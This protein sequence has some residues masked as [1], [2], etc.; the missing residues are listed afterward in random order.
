[1]VDLKSNEY[2]FVM[3]YV[4]FQHIPVYSIRK[5]LLQEILRVLKPGGLF[6][7][8]MLFAS[9]LTPISYYDDAP[10]DK[11]ER[12]DFQISSVDQLG[13]DLDNIGFIPYMYKVVPR[14]EHAGSEN[15]YVWARK[16]ND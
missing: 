6:S 13:E 12:L 10:V 1:L 14:P 15:I 9:P 8:Q 5:K 3:S 4:V 16:G 7:I 2:D 11:C